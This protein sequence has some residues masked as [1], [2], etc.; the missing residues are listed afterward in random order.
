[1]EEL[2]DII[3]QIRGFPSSKD[4]DVYGLNQRLEISTADLQWSSAEDDG[5]DPAGEITKETKQTFKDVA[6]SIEGA[7]RAFAK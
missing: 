2:R 7:S 6:G 1:M 4:E 3:S 5:F